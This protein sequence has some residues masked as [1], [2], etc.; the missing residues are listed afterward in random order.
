MGTALAI[1]IG[2]F[3]SGGT[4]ATNWSRFARSG[5]QRCTGHPAGLCL[6]QR[7]FGVCR[8]VFRPPFT[9]LKI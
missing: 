8:G 6:R 7:N 1:V 4:Q 9:V 2:T 3:I 5:A